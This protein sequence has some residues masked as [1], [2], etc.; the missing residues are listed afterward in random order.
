MVIKHVYKTAGKYSIKVRVSNPFNSADTWLCPDIVVVDA[1]RIEPQCS[2]F[3]VDVGIQSSEDI[4]VVLERSKELT[5]PVVPKLQCSIDLASL[6]TDYTWKTAR[7]DNA[8]ITDTEWRPELD[9]CATSLSN[10]LFEMP[11]RSLWYGMYR[12]SVTMGLSVK[13]FMG[14]K[15]RA[16]PTVVAIEEITKEDTA[17]EIANQNQVDMS[18]YKS[19]VKTATADFYLEVVKSDLIALIGGESKPEKVDYGKLFS[20]SRIFKFYQI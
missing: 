9:V 3:E 12:L 11:A 14:R 7:K 2:Q 10:P 18:G 6:Q 5:V 13:D 20:F 4:P 16:A 8:S 19:S 17:A 1:D 15:K